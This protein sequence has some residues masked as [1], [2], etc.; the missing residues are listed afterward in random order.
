VI[1]N[2]DTL[3][4]GLNDG[5]INFSG[6]IS[7]SL[8]GDGNYFMT[9]SIA[10][11]RIRVVSSEG[12]EKLAVIAKTRPMKYGFLDGT[13][14]EDT[15]HAY[16]DRENYEAVAI[17]NYDE[18][19]QKL[20]LK[21]IDALFMD[22]TVEGMFALYDNLI[23][24]DFVPISFNTVSMTTASENLEPVI[25][26]VSKYM[27]SAGSYKFTQMYE[28]G[29]AQYLHFNLVNQLTDDE[30]AYLDEHVQDGVA[31]HISSL[32]D[33][34]PVTF[35]NEKDEQWQGITVDILNKISELTGLTFV[36]EKRETSIA[37]DQ[38]LGELDVNNALV[39]GIVRTTLRES[40]YRFASDPYQTDYYA[41]ISS[42]EYRNLALSDVPYVRVGV[43]NES[44]YTEMFNTMFPNHANVASYETKNDAIRAL[45]NG[46]IDVLMGTRNMLLYITNYLEMTGYKA[47]LVLRRPYDVYFA[48][49][50]EAVELGGL[51][52]KAQKLVDTGNIVDGWTRRV[53]DYT[54]TMARAQ[55][56]FLIGSSILLVAI[57][58]L[59]MVFYLRN[60]QMA[61]RL[62]IQVRERTGELEV[63][64]AAAKVASQAKSE[65]LARMSHEIR[66][67]LNAI[68]GMTEIA[69]RTPE[70]VKKDTSLDEIASASGHLLG[71]LNDVLD[72]AKIESGKFA[73]SVEPFSLHMAMEEVAKIITQRCEEKNIK[74]SAVFGAD[75][76]FAL[77][78]YGVIGD[79]LR[80]KQVLINLLGNAVKFTPKDGEIYFRVGVSDVTEESLHVHFEV[81]DTGIGMTEDQMGNLFNAFEQADSTIAV[82]FGGT[83]L[84]LAI[85]QNLVGQMGGNITVKS[86]A[87]VGSTFEFTLIM[88][89]AELESTAGARVSDSLDFSGRRILLVED[90]DINRMILMELLSDTHVT[91]DEAEDGLI[92]VRRFSE[93]PPN[94]YDLVF[95]D[96]QMPNMNGYEATAAIRA[97]PREDAKTTPVLAMTANAYKEDIDRALASGMNGHLSKPINI[98]DVMGALQKYLG[99]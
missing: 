68:I 92:A 47:N 88:D 4:E 53:F 97:L 55:R 24:E 27:R 99:G 30:R 63:Q 64:T 89:R 7:S 6:E 96:V 31:I 43:L 8:A 33:N 25:S 65:F 86:T 80:L 84:G 36:Y 76:G 57:L 29:K 10:D 37:D 13:T 23:I 95:M 54:G 3:R 70:I 93:S 17:A 62:E 87:G 21:E 60:R 90:I 83:G 81:T 28:R 22:D 82:R 72:M 78:D 79:K 11:R 61:G 20:L 51:I 49:D 5:N 52:G 15:V 26:V 74:F 14:T 73:L 58:A 56:P 77:P 39:S 71:I 98:D 94:Y 41:F 75:N 66:T 1:Y 50:E 35:Y 34:Y 40:A 46:D 16:L 67:P 45:T 9:D 69:R 19:Y 2:W 59:L 85:S 12:M 18:A 48:V 38:L 32:S 91:I 42:S 44:A